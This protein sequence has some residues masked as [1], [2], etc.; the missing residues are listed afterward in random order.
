M[1]DFH[2]AFLNSWHTER[3]PSCE[4]MVGCA[5]QVTRICTAPR[6]VPFAPMTPSES[7]VHMQRIEWQFGISLLL[8]AGHG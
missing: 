5:N 2:K 6:D 1:N 3:R 4:A 7:C 8:R